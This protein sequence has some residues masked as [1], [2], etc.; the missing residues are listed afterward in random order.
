MKR[1]CFVFS[2]LCV[3]GLSSE[4]MWPQVV[5]REVSSKKHTEVVMNQQRFAGEFVSKFNKCFGMSLLRTE[6]VSTESGSFFEII[7]QEG[8]K[9]EFLPGEKECLNLENFWIT[10]M[11]K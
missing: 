8:R 3:C 7:D 5:N 1:L 10:Q 6:E 11:S 4:G 9:L 2:V